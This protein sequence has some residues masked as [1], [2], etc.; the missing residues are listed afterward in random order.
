MRWNYRNIKLLS[1]A[2]VFGLIIASTATILADNNLLDQVKNLR[3]KYQ[4]NGKKDPEKVAAGLKEALEVGAKNAVNLTGRV[5]GYFKNEAIKILMPQKLRDAEKVLR[6]L[7]QGAKADEFVLSMNRAAEKAAP[8]AKNIFLDAIKQMT[9]QDAMKIFNGNDTAATEYFREKTYL[10]LEAAFKSPVTKAMD[11][12]G[13]TR[14]YKEL[15]AKLKTIPLIK[16]E[17]VDIDNY[18]VTKALDGLFFMLGQEEKKIRKDPA[19]RV[20]ELLR[21]VFGGI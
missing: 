8:A 19:A 3:N 14:S 5:D 18:V 12:V 13:V 2:L 7:G 21:E 20:T 15:S 17:T 10:Q 16:V 4:N 1:F 11:Q 6:D 9:F